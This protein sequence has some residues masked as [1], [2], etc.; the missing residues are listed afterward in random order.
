MTDEEVDDWMRRENDKLVEEVRAS[1][2]LDAGLKDVFRRAE[3]YSAES[4]KV[5]PGCGLM[6]GHSDVCPVCND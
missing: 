4:L 5:C 3:E 1:L 2:D 6:I